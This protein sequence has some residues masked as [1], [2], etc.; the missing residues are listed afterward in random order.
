MKTGI[1]Y[2]FL[3]TVMTLVASCGDS[4]KQVSGLPE[5]ATLLAAV[6][7]DKIKGGWAGQ[8][9]GC[10]FGGPT[11]FKFKG[12]MIQDYQQMVWYDNYIKDIFESDPGLYDDV[13]MDLTFM[14]V[15]DR[16]GLD[17]PA[18]SF[19]LSFA[20]A[21]YKLWHAN[22]AAR[23][24]ILNGLWPP[25]SGNWMNNP[26]ADDID[27]QIESDFAGMMS[28]GMINTASEICDRTGHITNYG[29]GWY[30]GVF[31]AAMYAT[32]FISD[33]VDFIVDQGLKPIPENSRF[34]KA[35]SD[36]IKWHKQYPDDWKQC[37]F[38]FEKKNTSE[39]GCPE[40]VFN[41]FN[42][43][44]SVNAAYVVMGLLYGNKDF[45]KTMDIATRCGQ[46]S[47]CNP[48]TAGGI[49]G[50]ILGYDKIPAFWK[51]A[52]E[53]V[54]DLKFPYTNLTLNQVY[55]LSYKQA[56]TL[57]A[58]NGGEVNNET[59]SIKVQQPETV[60]FEQSFEG[61]YPV[62]E[63][64]VR[65]DILDESIKIDFTGTGIVVTGNVKSQCGV[66]T[67]DYVALLDVYIDGVKTEQVRMPF[68][69]IVRKYDIY[70]KYMLI[71][72]YHKLEIKWINQDPAYRIYF[73]SYVVYSDAPNK[74]F[75]P[76]K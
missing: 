43:D 38:E 17:A 58:K 63:L 12:T 16:V 39:K 57:I 1:K 50:V 73:K 49:L 6:L 27:F 28:P 4:S 60:R 37:W 9:I 34:Y 72:G 71:K 33:D 51:P 30:G 19:A 29:D 46:D 64:L 10:T 74:P 76:D 11:E 35:I 25:A 59:V 45:F 7:K 36:V 20:H 13:Y 44:A 68:D 21:D 8:T 15:L 52:V 5:K 62:K 67:S 24:N 55:D 42:I 18:D 66:A 23:Y 65:K 48:A 70:Y 32:A 61:M 22:Q 2:L 14:E 3:L 40:G 54:Q 31:M 26:H 47:D 53:M 56:I 75:E 41:S 69:F